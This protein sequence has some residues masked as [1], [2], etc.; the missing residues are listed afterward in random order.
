M[1]RVADDARSAVSL[2]RWRERVS[3]TVAG[4]RLSCPQL[5]RPTRN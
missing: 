1:L 2:E 5:V 4:P 3:T